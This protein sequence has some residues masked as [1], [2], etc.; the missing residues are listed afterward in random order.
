MASY[1]NI[2]DISQGL[3]IVS[4]ALHP[5]CIYLIA[6][7]FFDK[8]KHGN[9]CEDEWDFIG[10]FHIYLYKPLFMEQ[11]NDWQGKLY[12]GMVDMTRVAVIPNRPPAF[13]G[14]ISASGTIIYQANAKEE[15][16]N[17]QM[18]KNAIKAR[19][20]ISDLAVIDNDIYATSSG[21]AVYKRITDENWEEIAL[22]VT[23]RFFS[24]DSFTNG[25][26]CIDGFSADE[27]YVGG[28]KGI[29]WIC[30]KGKWR[31]IDLPYNKD[32]EQIV[33]APDGYVYLNCCWKILKGRKDSWQI[34]D[35]DNHLPPS[36][37]IAKMSWFKGGVYLLPDAASAIGLYCYRND[38]I[39]QVPVG[40]IQIKP[41]KTIS[42]NPLLNL[43]FTNAEVQVFIPGG[44]N[45]MMANDDLLMITG[46]NAV[47]L[48]DGN[49]WFNLFN[50]N[51]S[52]EE[53]RATGTFYDP[54]EL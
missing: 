41:K 26:D 18:T 37:G 2:K 29:L 45:D 43:E 31:P 15:P 4:G 8:K 42:N 9:K 35:I 20:R 36:M 33:C 10:K 25:F 5:E 39:K 27:I 47:I 48:F 23:E 46:G 44:L 53:L 22:S 52:E 6:E 21:G 13:L 38:I 30:D 49:R 17:F 12:S 24:D 32:I 16:E 34:I 3:N 51:K 50:K 19:G 1:E 54:R 40:N 14:C 11:G 7:E 28:E